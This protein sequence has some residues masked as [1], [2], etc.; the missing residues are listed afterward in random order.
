MPAYDVCVFVRAYDIISISRSMY[1]TIP[2]SLPIRAS[3]CASSRWDPAPAVP[4]PDQPKNLGFHGLPC[5]QR[6][7]FA[8]QDWTIRRTREWP[9]SQVMSAGARDEPQSAAVLAV[10]SCGEARFTGP[11]G[12]RREALVYD[13]GGSMV[14]VSPRRSRTV[15][16]DPG[17]Q[18][19]AGVLPLSNVF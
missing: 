12:A 8:S 18:P 13:W 16:V 10:P 14:T 9:A 3:S 17:W 1:A 6:E 4:S 2:S 7:G 19:R 15:P 11:D 5:S